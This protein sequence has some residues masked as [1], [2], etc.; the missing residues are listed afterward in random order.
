[1]CNIVWI[2]YSF[3]IILVTNYPDFR[4]IKRIQ[5][6]ESNCKLVVDDYDKFSRFIKWNSP[7]LLVPRLL[8]S[9]LSDWTFM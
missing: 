1:M 9:F 3:Q 4:S 7:N 8:N 2:T 5:R 6:I